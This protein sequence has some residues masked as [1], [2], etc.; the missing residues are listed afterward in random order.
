[1]SLALASGCSQPLSTA[2]PIAT[3]SAAPTIAAHPAK[4]YKIDVLGPGGSH[5]YGESDNVMMTSG[6]N[7]VLVQDG[8]LS[9]NGKKYGLLNDK[10]TIVIDEDGKVKVN[11][12]SRAPEPD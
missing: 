9:V 11:G 1:M 3:S 7:A 2:P 12:V 10:D 4:S 8:R 6:K 5:T